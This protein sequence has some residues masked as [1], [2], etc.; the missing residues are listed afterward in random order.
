LDAFGAKVGGNVFLV[1]GFNAHG[2]VSLAHAIVEGSLDLY[3]VTSPDMFSLDLRFDR[4]ATLKDKGDSWPKQGDL[5]LHGLRYT[6]IHDDSPRDADSRLEWLGRQATQPFRSQPYEQLAGVFKTGGYDADARKVLI[7]KERDRARYTRMSSIG[8]CWHSLLG[9][10]IGYG[11]APWRA[12]KISL[13][14]VLVGS[15][16]FKAA[17][18]RGLITPSQIKGY[19]P[20]AGENVQRLLKAYPALNSLVYSFDVFV[21]VVNL[22]QQSYWLPNKHM[23]RTLID[24]K[25]FRLNLGS[26]LRLYFW[27]HIIAGWILT[28]L[29]VVGLTGLVRR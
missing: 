13:V 14:V 6:E 24:F 8:R 21:P 15:I 16:L 10:T 28:T 11:H 27:L 17:F 18:S 1:D 29:L 25:G 2:E 22:H 23:G 12:L 26:L 19:D 9:W 4:V 7:A 3:G 20:D 5:L